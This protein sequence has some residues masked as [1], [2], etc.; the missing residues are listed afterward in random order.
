MQGST[1]DSHPLD[2]FIRPFGNSWF[3]LALFVMAITAGVVMS[4]QQENWQWVNRFGG[5]A[6]ISGLLLT[7][8]PIFVRGVYK[9]QASIGLWASL[10]GDGNTVE[11]TEEDRHVG[12]RVALGIALSLIG[13]LVTSFGDI[14]ASSLVTSLP[15]IFCT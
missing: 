3:C 6:T 1:L 10:D 2:K 11:T 14:A 8:S 7:L 4:I 9:S 15:E 5:V 12:R 13:T